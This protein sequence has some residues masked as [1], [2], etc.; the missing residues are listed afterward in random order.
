MEG[1]GREGGGELVLG[2]GEGRCWGRGSPPLAYEQSGGRVISRTKIVDL[3]LGRSALP[4]W[5]RKVHCR[6]N[7]W[8]PREKLWRR[9]KSCRAYLFENVFAFG[10]AMVWVI[11]HVGCLALPLWIRKVHCRENLWRPREKLWRCAVDFR[12]CFK[13]EF[14]MYTTPGIICKGLMP[15]VTNNESTHQTYVIVHTTFILKQANST[16]CN[17][18]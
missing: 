18:N 13:F 12:G 7:L 14:E 1:E 10:H 17:R 8:R 11:A 3:R 15:G 2:E 5:I 9:A 6:E 4:P 16:H